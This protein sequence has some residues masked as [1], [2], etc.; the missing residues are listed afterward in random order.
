[1]KKIL[2]VCLGN[3]CRS[4]MAEFIFNFMVKERGL[5]KD[6]C[7]FSKATSYEEEGHGPYRKALLK[8]A[9]KGIPTYGHK[10]SRIEESDYVCYD[11]IVGMED[12]NV[13]NILRIVKNDSQKKVY[14]LLD[15]CGGGD[16]ADPWY[17][18]DF[19]RAF[20]DIKRGCQAFIDFLQGSL[21]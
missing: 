20:C 12:Y 8:L 10:S 14:K 9:E 3:I 17:T 16:I 15:F 11:F 21:L 2:F 18:D 4:P 19:E 5:E 6:F 1:M 13:K 7:A